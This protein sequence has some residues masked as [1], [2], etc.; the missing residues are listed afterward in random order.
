[1]EGELDI[2]KRKYVFSICTCLEDT[3][4]AE[5]SKQ[6]VTFMKTNRS[7]KDLIHYVDKTACTKTC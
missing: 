2:L 1:M 3:N 4:A 7:E 6:I 5:T